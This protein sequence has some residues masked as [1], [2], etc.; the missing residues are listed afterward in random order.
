MHFLNHVPREYVKGA[1]P[2]FSKSS[3]PIKTSSAPSSSSSFSTS[4]TSF[5]PRP[6][7]SDPPPFPNPTDFSIPPKATATISCMANAAYLQRATFTFPR[8]MANVTFEGNGEGYPMT[9][10]GGKPTDTVFLPQPTPSPYNLIA[11]FEYAESVI[12]PK[13]LPAQI[14]SVKTAKNS[15]VVGTE[16]AFDGDNDDTVATI[17]WT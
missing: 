10:V 3:S 17:Q 16:D 13:F 7:Q 6:S 4:I 14:M 2:I 15:I 5:G 12:S 11:Y 1:T 9:I 8:P